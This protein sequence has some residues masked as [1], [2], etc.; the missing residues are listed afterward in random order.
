MLI[1]VSGPTGL[2]GTA[3]VERLERDGCEVRRLSRSPGR[4]RVTWDP[5]AGRLDPGA[6]DGVHGVVHLAGESIAEGRW[7]A[8]RK[9][10]IRE[11]RVAGT[12]LLARAAAAATPRPRFFVSASALGWY[13]DRGDT[14]LDE[15]APAGMGFLPD[16]C[17]AWEA[18][19]APARAAGIRTAAVRIGLVLATEG[20]AL[21]EMLP[22]FR[23]GLGGPLGSG[24]QYWSWIT[25]DDVVGAF[26]HVIRTETLEG[27]VNA[28]AGAV[29]NREFTRTLNRVLGRPTFL[30]VPRLALR[31]LMGEMADGL[32]LASARLVPRRLAD[33]G[34]RW[35]D[36]GLEPALRRLLDRPT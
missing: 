31:L 16:V 10:A 26:T 23:L 33:S 28:V 27:P 1:L 35:N 29:T 18:A 25:L 12:D 13:G 14:P 24:R 6:F 20:G 11:S 36:P 2:I 3:L 32:L 17:R 15:S 34:F 9:A 22:P 30:P 21:K 8:A 4:G 7:T 19:A 5:A